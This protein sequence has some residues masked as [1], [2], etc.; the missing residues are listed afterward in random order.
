M[1]YKIG[2]CDFV[3]LDGRVSNALGNCED[4][5]ESYYDRA[6]VQICELNYVQSEYVPDIA[7]NAKWILKLDEYGE[8][9]IEPTLETKE[10]LESRE[11][12]VS[13]WQ[14]YV[15]QKI[16][17]LMECEFN[18]PLTNEFGEEVWLFK[19]SDEPPWRQPAPVGTIFPV[20]E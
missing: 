19:D 1:G 4:F 18:F 8:Y 17:T 6:Y 10:L 14:D 20:G 13:F 12:I 7:F 9:H 3:N 11:I 15:L 2:K 5:T 16:Q